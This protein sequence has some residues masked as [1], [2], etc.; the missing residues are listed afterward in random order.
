MLCCT[1]LGCVRHAVRHFSTAV[2]PT[3]LAPQ[4]NSKHAKA[5]CAFLLG[6][7]RA[8]GGWG[9]S[10][11]SCQ[12]KVGEDLVGAGGLAE[13][14]QTELGRGWGKDCLSCQDKVGGLMAS[15]ATRRQ[16]FGA[17]L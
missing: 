14:W 7:Q 5:A 16:V 2:F 10:Y 15:G 6:K 1:P 9:E 13:V 17:L 8:D 3:V 11:L 12:D 4:A